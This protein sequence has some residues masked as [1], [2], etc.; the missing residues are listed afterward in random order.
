[1][2]LVEIPGSEGADVSESCVERIV[3]KVAHVA[4]GMFASGGG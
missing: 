2:P 3:D 1:M 4:Y